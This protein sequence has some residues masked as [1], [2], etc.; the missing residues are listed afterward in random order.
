MWSIT[1]CSYRQCV[2]LVLGTAT[3]EGR[4]SKQ[5]HSNTVATN[6]VWSRSRATTRSLCVC[7]VVVHTQLPTIES[8]VCGLRLCIS[9]LLQPT[10]RLRVSTGAPPAARPPRPNAPGGKH[11]QHGGL[12]QNHRKTTV[13][14]KAAILNS[15][16][17][18]YQEPNKR[19]TQNVT[20]CTLCAPPQKSVA[21]RA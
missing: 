11:Q 14:H 18:L 13:V 5:K 1:G 12:L 16:T 2:Q 6:M 9:S 7:V 15:L 17:G 19:E 8:P 4:R 21:W 10:K 20:P 3:K